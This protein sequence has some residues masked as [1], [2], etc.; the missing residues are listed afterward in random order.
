MYYT[1]NKKRRFHV[2]LYKYFIKFYKINIYLYKIIVK[3]EI[4]DNFLAI[5]TTR[6]IGDRKDSSFFQIKHKSDELPDI[7]RVHCVIYFYEEFA[8]VVDLWSYNGT[9]VVL[10]EKVMTS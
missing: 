2:L 8:V 9:D 5:G 10:G 1:N 7:S 3:I 6:D 4:K